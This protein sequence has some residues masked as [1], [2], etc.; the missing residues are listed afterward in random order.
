MRELDVNTDRMGGCLS[1]FGSVLSI[2]FI[3][4]LAGACTSPS[5]VTHMQPII[6]EDSKCLRWQEMYVTGAFFLEKNT[7]YI[8]CVDRGQC[9]PQ[10][11]S[12]CG[13]QHPQRGEVIEGL[14]SWDQFEQRIFGPGT[15]WYPEYY[16]HGEEGG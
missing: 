4:V 8:H 9:F 3:L 5:W 2:A 13:I 11:G 7:L 10:D 12:I 16:E 14:S 6:R 1:L 15:W